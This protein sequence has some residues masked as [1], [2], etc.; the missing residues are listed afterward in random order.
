MRHNPS[1]RRRR[2]AGFTLIELLVVLVILGVLAGIVMPRLFGRGEEA[3]RTAAR[4]QM[5][6]LEDALNQYEVDT[7]TYPTT[8]QGLEALIREPTVG[9][10]PE[11]WREGGYLEKATVPKD[12]WGTDY[13]YLSPGNHGSFDLLSYGPDGE[14]GG[15]GKYADIVNWELE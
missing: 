10:I 1:S 4:V 13:V 12:P 7:G 6:I 2:D 5:R 3:K 15:D 8:E 9:R 11:R 14:P